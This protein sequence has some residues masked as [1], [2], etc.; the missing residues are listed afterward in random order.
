[1]SYLL[2]DLRF[3]ASRRNTI[4]AVR[5]F[6]GGERSHVRLYRNALMTDFPD[7]QHIDAVK[8]I[9]P[10][11]RQ[12]IPSHSAKSHYF[13][14]AHGGMYS[15]CVSIVVHAHF[16]LSDKKCILLSCA[17]VFLCT[18]FYFMHFLYDNPKCAYKYV[19]WKIAVNKKIFNFSQRHTET[20][21]I[22]V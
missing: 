21:Q 4:N 19:D 9:G 10:L 1:M 7:K 18:F 15:K 14:N 20:W 13:F 8:E 11:V 12:V 3:I 2:N 6:R 22:K 17:H 16:F 5:S